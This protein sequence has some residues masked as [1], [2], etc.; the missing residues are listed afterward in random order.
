MKLRRLP[1]EL[2]LEYLDTYM[3]NPKSPYF[4]RELDLV[5]LYI[6]IDYER[7]TYY[8]NL[9]IARIYFQFHYIKD[10]I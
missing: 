4:T 3:H 9:R 7:L 10:Y 6:D 2:V 1:V 5:S 8:N